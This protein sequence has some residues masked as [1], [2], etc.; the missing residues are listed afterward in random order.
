M[1]TAYRS[2]G[3]DRYAAWAHETDQGMRT[4]LGGR[5]YTVEDT[6]R[7]MG[8]CLDDV[9]RRDSAVEVDR[10]NW[11]EHLRPIGVPGLSGGADP[12]AFRVRVA[13]LGGERRNCDG[14]RP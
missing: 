4:E 8:M 6:T 12:T 9:P 5:G 10:A 1:E 2:A 7:A 3:V 14:L 13:Q 11:D